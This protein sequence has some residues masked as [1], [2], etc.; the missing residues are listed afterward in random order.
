MCIVQIF[1][2][3]RA[4]PDGGLVMATKPHARQVM[5][6][7]DFR[8]LLGAEPGE[9]ICKTAELGRVL[10]GLGSVIKIN[11]TTLMTCG[12]QI[13]YILA[14]HGCRVFFDPK[15]N[16]VDSTLL[17]YASMLTDLGEVMPEFVTVMSDNVSVA[18]LAR[19]QEI[20]GEQTKLCPVTIL[21]NLTGTEAWE[22]YGATLQALTL[23]RS[24][25]IA[26]AG[27]THAV[28]PGSQINNVFFQTT[29]HL[30]PI[31]TGIRPQGVNQD[32]HAR[33]ITA[34]KAFGGGA[35]Y[36]VVGRNFI[37][38]PDYHVAME[39]LLREAEVEMQ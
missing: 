38:Q 11:P 1:V 7:A 37:A 12:K 33:S 8:K 15:W 36:V 32:E 35:G 20:L 16:D 21:S 3:I 25:K 2:T 17:D 18:T 13:F 29:P 39:S 31:A 5:V 34:G 9:I 4:D 22:R 6:A 23:A 19:M 28:V 26:V 30:T 10:A 14:H 27:L 24:T